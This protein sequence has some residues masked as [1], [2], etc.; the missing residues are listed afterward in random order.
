[1][2]IRNSELLKDNIKNDTAYDQL[3]CTISLSLSRNGVKANVWWRI[4]ETFRIRIFGGNPT[5]CKAKPVEPI[6]W[7]VIEYS[8]ELV[9]ISSVD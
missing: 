5:K 7:L 3:S 8:I 2:R 9:S 1:M 4:A 6:K